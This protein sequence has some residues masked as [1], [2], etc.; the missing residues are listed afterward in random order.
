[1][2]ICNQHKSYGLNYLHVGSFAINYIT[3]TVYILQTVEIFNFTEY[4]CVFTAMSFV[5]DLSVRAVNCALQNLSAP[6]K[7]NKLVRG[8]AG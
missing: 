3:R 6:R 8:A 2:Y 4:L 5:H 7:H 1:M